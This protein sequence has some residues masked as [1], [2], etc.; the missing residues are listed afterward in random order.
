[1]EMESLAKRLMSAFAEALDLEVE[2]FDP[3]IVNPISALRALNYP[4]TSEVTEERQQRAG[5]HTD[6]GSLT[7]LLP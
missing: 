6:Y 2:F 7:I 3:F 5:A 4:A 1:M